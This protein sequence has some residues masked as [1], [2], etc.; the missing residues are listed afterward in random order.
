[1]A[2]GR[3]G[4]VW[5]EQQ[6]RASDGRALGPA[7]VLAALQDESRPDPETQSGGPLAVLAAAQAP[8]PLPVTLRFG[9]RTLEDLATDEARAGLAHRLTEAGLAVTGVDA[10]AVGPL[11]GERV[12]ER[13]FLPDWSDEARLHHTTAVA[14]LVDMLAPPGAPVAVTTLPCARRSGALDDGTAADIADSLLRAAA[15]LA[16]IER[17]SGRRLTLALLPTPFCLLET[18]AEAIAFFRRWLYAPTAIRRFAALADLS[19]ADAADCLPGH[20]AV[21]LDTAHAAVVGE[22]AGE[23]IAALRSV[24][25]PLR[26]L[27]LSVSTRVAPVTEAALE[28]VMVREGARG[29]LPAIGADPAGMAL[30]IPDL[31][32][33]GTDLAALAGADLRLLSRR[34]LAPADVPT[35]AF[36][37]RSG[38]EAVLAVHRQR[39]LAASVEM[40]APATSTPDEL[41]RDLAWLTSRLRTRA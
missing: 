29:L 4:Q 11:I 22:D 15:H 37:D 41:A 26:V 1:M 30:R 27:R 36:A 28:A 31:T 33:P 18:V 20:L 10:V 19:R 12:K 34:P 39:P 38:V 32:D 2:E 25:I 5:H 14:D 23:A 24:G 16:W 7:V 35:A 6:G 3:P 17:Q 40:V 9:A 8:A 21:G 13:A